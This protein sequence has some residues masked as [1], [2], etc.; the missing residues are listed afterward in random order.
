[1]SVIDWDTDDSNSIYNKYRAFFG[2]WPLT[3]SWHGTPV[4]LLK[5]CKSQMPNLEP[6]LLPGEIIY[7]KR[8][9]ILCVKCG[10]KGGY[11]SIE[12]LKITGH[13]TMLG[14]DFFNGFVYMRPENERKFENIKQFDN[15]M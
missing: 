2:L 8:K 1:M 15:R 9:H 12:K 14:K 5:V 11:L 10:G 7:D 6:Q 3:T 4:K 13:K